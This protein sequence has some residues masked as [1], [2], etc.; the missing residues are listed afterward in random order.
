MERQE[1]FAPIAEYA[2]V[3]DGRTVALVCSDG[4]IDWWPLPTIDSPP[5][6]AAL[7]DPQRGGQVT[8]APSE[9]FASTRR[10]VE[11]TNVLETTFTTSSGSVKVTD[12]TNVSATGILPWGELVRVVEGIE[13]E[14]EVRWEVAP[15]DRFG[16]AR[17][18]AATDRGGMPV[19]RLGDQ[20][21]GLVC[22]DV[23]EP[24]V[25]PHRVTGGFT[26]A[27]GSSH[28]LGIVTTDAEPLYFPSAKY[29][30][31]RQSETVEWWKAWDRRI[32]Y[33][34]PWR[35]EVCRSVLALKLLTYAST[36]AI[37]AAPT[38]SLPEILGGPKNYD[39][40]FAWVRDMAFA[41]G[42]MLR[43]GV[44]EEVHGSLSWLLSTVR[45]TAPDVHVFYTADGKVADTAADVA[46]PGYRGSQPV[47]AGNKAEGQTQLESFGALFDPVCAYVE[48]GHH[49]DGQTANMIGACADRVCDIW[50]ETDAGLWELTDR[51]HYTA[52]K[53]GCWTAL[54]RAVRMADAGEVASRQ[55]DRWAAERDA[56]AAWVH[57][58]CWS[59]TK[60]SYTF[61]AGTDDLDAATLLSARIA[62]DRGERMSSTIDALRSELGHGPLLYRYS[63]MVGKEGA[64]LACSFWMVEAL[65][66]TGRLQEAITLMD[67]CCGLANDVGLYSEEM[68]PDTHEML[69]NFPQALTHL[70]LVNAAAMIHEVSE[71]GQD[72][73]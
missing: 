58:H 25:E 15:G 1:G 3:G 44:E 2:A 47:Q 32:H 4:A 62:F 67:E 71:D 24:D 43:L 69:G 22:T 40:R 14:V 57:D 31:R 11:G 42:A 60:G 59:G 18:W 36:G 34:G 56:I 61:Y 19:I 70:A 48:H 46:V 72:T 73:R 17:P 9:P 68:D 38:T 55:R 5:A 50:M 63:E 20:T 66:V 30:V 7:L 33:Q 65:A 54:D 29:I 6:F 51:Q 8:L 21:L 16:S 45:R 35:K 12:S 10:Y 28:S 41:I 27:P 26:T 53:V 39:Y 64:F 52:S 13:G 49:L 23:G 37:L